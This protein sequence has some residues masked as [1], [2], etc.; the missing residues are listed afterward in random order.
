MPAQT[1]SQTSTHSTRGRKRALSTAVTRE[2]SDDNSE[3]EELAWEWLYS[4]EQSEH[5]E[6]GEGDRKRRKVATSSKIVGARYGDF[7]CRVGDTVM[8]KAE[9]FNESWVAIICDFRED[10]ETGEM[11]ANF[12]WFL[13]EKEVPNKERKREDFLWVS[14]RAITLCPQNE[15]CSSNDRSRMSCIYLPLGM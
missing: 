6:D 12:M 11:E 5:G 3:S 9:G 8:L 1:I 2:G 7:E 15:F 4:T 10:D 13:T 14:A